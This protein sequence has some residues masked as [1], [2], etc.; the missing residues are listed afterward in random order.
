M[1]IE[2]KE[3]CAGSYVRLKSG[4]PDMK[5]T[6]I[7]EAATVQWKGEKGETHYD[8]FPLHCIEIIPPKAV[9]P[10]AKRGL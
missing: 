4:G 10:T 3:I 6:D 1:D 9:H 7:I 8:T 2:Q 5:V